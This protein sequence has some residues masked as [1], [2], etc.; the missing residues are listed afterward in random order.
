MNVSTRQPFLSSFLAIAL[1]ALPSAL[2][3]IDTDSDGLDDS[4][5]T[6]T[7]TYVSP[8]NTGT[9]PN[10][11]DSDAD[12]AGDWYEVATIDVNP[13]SP[14]PNAPNSAAIKPNIPYPLPA[15]DS[16]PPATDKPVKVYILSGQSNMVGQGKISP[17]GTAGTL[18]TITK[19]EHKFPNLLDGAAWS[20]RN[21]V[22]YR[23]VIAAIGNSALTPGHNNGTA[24]I[25]PELG[26]GHVMGYHHDEPVLIIKSSEGGR[27]I[28][29]DFLPPGSVAYTVGSTAYAGYGDSPG[30]WTTAPTPGP[31]QFYGGYQFDQ[32]FLRKADWSSTGSANAT[33]INV[34]TV[35]D[36]FASQYPQWAAQGFE[37][38]GFAWFQGWNDGLSYTPFYA[39]RYEQ[40]M[41]QFIRQIRAYYDSRYPGKIQPKAPFVIATCAFEGWDGSYNDNYPTRKAVLNAQ[42]AVGDDAVK[43]P[44]FAGNVKTVEARGYWRSISASPANN[45]SHYNLNAETYMLVGDAMGRAMIDLIGSSSPDTLPPVITG[46]NPLD[47]ATSLA[48]NTNLLLTFNEALALGTGNITLKNLT[49]STQSTI[50]ITD[51]SQVSINGAFLTINPTSD[52]AGGKSYAIRIDAGALKDLSDNPF[53]GIADDTTW[54]F[55][56]LAPDTTAPAISSRSPSD[57]AGSVTVGSNLIMTFNE[58]VTLGSGN[59]TIRNLSNSTQTTIPVTDGTKVSLSGSILTVNPSANLAGNSNLAIRI[60]AGVVKDTANNP[61]PGIGDDTT[62]NFSI[63]A[64]PTSAE[65]TIV[66]QAEGFLGSDK[67]KV[68]TTHNGATLLSYNASGVSKLVVA[69]GTESGFNNNT[70]TVTGVKFN[71]VA[72]TQA[73]QENAR[74]NT[75]YDGGTAAIYYLDDPLQGSATFTVSATTSGGSL[76][77]GWVSVI[78]LTG[79]SPGLG[80]TGTNWFTQATSGNVSTSL[81][82]SAGK[83][84]V[85]AAV[86]N[87]GS[88]SSAG[89][90]TVVAPLTLSNNGNWGSQWGSGASAY[91]FVPASGT[92]VTPTFNTAAGGNIHV[93]AVEIKASEI[94]PNAY[95]FWSALYPSANPDPSA[96]FDGGGLPTGIEWVVGGNPTQGGDDAGL[97]PTINNT[98]DPDGKFLFTYRR[99]DAANLDPNTTIAVEYGGALT[100]WSAAVH[101][102]TGANQITI[103]EAPDDPGFS[104]VTVA[105]PGDLTV[106]NKLFVRLKVMVATP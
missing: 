65:I 77:G 70:A 82:T 41:A 18:E 54:N 102:G 52:L 98:A 7:G 49:D 68:T 32:C 81:T 24:T 33:V 21:D 96:D 37:I 42:L 62:W 17:L 80:N 47:N 8:T 35:L 16:T 87:S 74:T 5:E 94:T 26:F 92:T 23:G 3:A 73:A 97:T 99:S 86:E 67:T 55:T 38:A 25:G 64:P 4:V 22:M 10:N 106:S 45:Q 57:N 20:V 13:A 9:N 76:N 59:I 105:L 58:P 46:F 93:V 79:T 12:G 85:V 84:L 72:L 71:G 66:S 75:S 51:G 11:P 50:S 1:I 34:T 56:T 90:P 43:Y 30:S 100:G 29:W 44:D 27:A 83:S 101:Q 63:A 60:D 36:N 103:T 19:N 91:Q 78:G 104:L 40:N 88:Q 14:Q 89:T 6:N 53:A 39:N 48:T 15:P 95:E 69:V 28:G 61:F 2:Y 31:A